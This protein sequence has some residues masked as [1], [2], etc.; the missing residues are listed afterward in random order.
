MPS[1]FQEKLRNLRQNPDTNR[2]GLKWDS[3]EDDQMFSMLS[4]GNSLADIAK[5]LQRTEGSIKTRLITYAI[6]KMEKEN[7]S[8]EQVASMVNLS[9]TDIIEYQQKKQA[10]DE[11]MK[12]RKESKPPKK[13]NVN[14]I[15]NT[16]IYD[17]LQNIHKSIERLEK[18]VSK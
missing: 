17:L 5:A 13:T 18:V 6:N 2:A 15:T 3:G 1:Q 12:Q 16:D 10:R 9:E 7:L 8:L 14:N 11:R 4:S